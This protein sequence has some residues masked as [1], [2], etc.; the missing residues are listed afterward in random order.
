M[1]RIA[2][3]LL[4]LAAILGAQAEQPQTRSID[5]REVIQIALLADPDVRL[6]QLAV[7]RSANSLALVHAESATQ[8]YGGSGLGATAGIPQSVLGANPSIAQVTLRQPLL[9]TERPGRAKSAR[10]EI[11]SG[12]HQAAAIAERAAYVAGI[13]YLDFELA[14]A[15]HRRKQGE[16]EHFQRIESST[17]A[18]VEEGFEIPLALSRARL[19]TARARDRVAA[20]R[21]RA[22]LMEAELRRMLGMGPDVRLVADGS[23]ADSA[24]ALDAAHRGLAGRPLGEHPEIAALDASMRAARYRASSAKAARNPRLDIVGQYSL[25]AR[26]NNYDDYFRRF[27]RHNWQAGIAVEIP[28]FTGRGVAERVTRATLDERELVLRKAAK[29]T[30]LA[31]ASQRAEAALEEARRGRALAGQELAY[32]RESLDVL[33]A[34][35]EEGRIA[36]DELQRGRIEESA[37][38]GGLIAA[39]YALAKA[40]LG[41]VYAVGRIRDAFA[42]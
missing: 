25:L 35:F 27:Q 4:L 13:A 21:S 36:L 26:F 1:T 37:A 29:S 34:Q 14:L 16:L 40:R 10:E 31:V 30:E 28:I 38:W 22:D 42:D 3:F 7:E 5:L 6:A 12:E 2:T 23:A 24:A 9:D 18:R 19:D 32:A 15:E 33:L 8:L 20:S 39:E 41:S 11:Q 17:A